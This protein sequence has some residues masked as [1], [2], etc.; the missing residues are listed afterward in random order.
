MPGQLGRDLVID[1]EDSD[2]L[3]GGYTVQ[4]DNEDDRK[5]EVKCSA[6]V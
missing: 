2:D 6:L 4:D 1:R 5:D 3:E